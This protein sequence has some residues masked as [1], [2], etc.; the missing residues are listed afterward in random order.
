MHMR[1]FLIFFVCSGMVCDGAFFSMARAEDQSE[2]DPAP[3][4][5][6]TGYPNEPRGF[7]GIT[8]GTDVAKLVELREVPANAKL[9]RDN[10]YDVHE[11]SYVKKDAR[12]L[13]TDEINFLEKIG[14]LEVRVEYMFY[15]GKFYKVVLEPLKSD[16]ENIKES[17]RILLMG[18]EI[19]YGEPRSGVGSANPEMNSIWYGNNV[20]IVYQN[21]RKV[22]IYIYK[23]IEEQILRD[24]EKSHGLQSQKDTKPDRKSAEKVAEDL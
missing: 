1:I 23:P 15:K 24:R 12:I 7:H 3:D 13:L 4:M 17:A 6:K 20:D 21:D 16:F 9:L 14:D 22:F 2:S 19:K 8:W 18:L 5:I 11:D 10:E